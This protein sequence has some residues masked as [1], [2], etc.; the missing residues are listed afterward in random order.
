[1]DCLALFGISLLHT[2]AAKHFERHSHRFPRHAGLFHLSGEVEVVSVDMAPGIFR[3]IGT[4]PTR[5]TSASTGD[6]TKRRVRRGAQQVFACAAY[7][8]LSIPGVIGLNFSP[9]FP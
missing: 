3:T 9:I 6:E 7:C 2:F 8:L 1:M 4:A 5:L